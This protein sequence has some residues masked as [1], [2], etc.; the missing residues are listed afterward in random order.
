MALTIVVTL[1]AESLFVIATRTVLFYGAEQGF[2]AVV[3]LLLLLLVSGHIP[4]GIGRQGEVKHSIHIL[5][6]GAAI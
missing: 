2:S 3:V 5:N 6:S 1:V 4:K